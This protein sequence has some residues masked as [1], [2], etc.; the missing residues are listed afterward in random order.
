MTQDTPAQP[1]VIP[2]PRRRGKPLRDR[3]L[4]GLQESTEV[5]E[6]DGTP[7]LLWTRSVNNKGYGQ[8]AGEDGYKLVLVHRAYWELMNGP[9]VGGLPVDH[10]CRN[11]R[12]VRHLEVVTTGENNRRAAEVRGTVVPPPRKE[13]SKTR[14][15]PRKAKC[16]RGHAMTDANVREYVTPTG[17]VQRTCL[18][19]EQIRRLAKKK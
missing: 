4:S 7:H 16:I 11:K 12:C 8:L 19:C 9:I 5:W 6:G 18:E 14:G 10:L 17:H 15:R 1:P 3:L 2:A 13:L